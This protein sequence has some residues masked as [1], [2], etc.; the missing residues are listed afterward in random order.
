MVVNKKILYVS[1]A[2]WYFNLHWVN[3][4]R[5]ALE[6]GFEVHVAA[7]KTSDA[8]IGAI[9]E[10]GF[11]PHEYAIDRRSVNPVKEAATFGQLRRIITHVRPDIIHSFTIKPN[12]YCGL[13]ARK[14]NIPSIKSITGTGAV[15]AGSTLHLRL[16]KYGVLA[17]YRQVGRAATGAFVFENHD[18]RAFFQHHRISKFQPL[19]VVQ[20]AGIDTNSY[21]LTPM[22]ESGDL[23]VLF[24]ARLLRDKGL[25]VLV[26]AVRQLKE[27]RIPVS[28]IVAGIL[29]KEACNG[30]RVSELEKLHRQGIIQWIGRQKNMPDLIR[31]VH[32]VALPTLYGEGIPRIL[33]EGASCGRALVASDA[34]GCREIVAHGVNGLLVDPCNGKDLAL[35]LE[36]LATDRALLEQFGNAGRRMVEDWFDEKLVIQ[37]TLDIYCDMLSKL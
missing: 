28:L 3:R 35:A 15:F 1:N 21:S 24:A 34:P 23:K 36:K 9:K 32:V 5:A 2:D 16:L 27:K 19:I 20:G 18:N 30:I 13:I 14:N 31:D 10:E 26:K 8:E 22:P 12:L 33:I 17:L 6:K 37:Q 11:I 7:G 25:D 29:D 4:A